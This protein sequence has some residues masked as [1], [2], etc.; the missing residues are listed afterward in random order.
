M[1]GGGWEKNKEKKKKIKMGCKWD[2]RLGGGE[3]GEE[4]GERG[5][6]NKEG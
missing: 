3:K 6:K 5:G 1:W 2:V 4:R